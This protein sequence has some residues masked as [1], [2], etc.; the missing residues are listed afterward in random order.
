MRCTADLSRSKLGS[1]KGRARVDDDFGAW[2]PSQHESLV[3][4]CF[5]P[6]AVRADRIAGYLASKPCR[7]LIDMTV[8]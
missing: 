1:V 3:W 2:N 5:M 7:Q 6:N 4:Q 8:I